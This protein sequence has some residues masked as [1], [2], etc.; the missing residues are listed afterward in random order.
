MV[1]M[2]VQGV[3]GLVELTSSL[4]LGGNLRTK[5]TQFFLG[6]HPFHLINH[7][8]HL[9]SHRINEA[10]FEELFLQDELLI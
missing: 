4:D 10:I 2:L 3:K 8:I 5:L 9:G 6:G 7:A 1:D